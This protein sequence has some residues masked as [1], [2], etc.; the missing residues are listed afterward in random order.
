MTRL[1][2]QVTEA[3]DFILELNS[4]VYARMLDRIFLITQS[5][6]LAII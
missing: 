5:T 1:R 3:A 2:L 6:T 4:W